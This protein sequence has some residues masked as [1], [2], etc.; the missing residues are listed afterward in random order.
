M[1]DTTA[2][3]GSDA[4]GSFGI[5]SL[6]AVLTAGAGPLPIVQYNT[7][8][9]YA[10]GIILQSQ[11][12]QLPP[13]GSNHDVLSDGKTPRYWLAQALDGWTNVISNPGSRTLPVGTGHSFVYVG[14]KGSTNNLPKD[15]TVVKSPTDLAAVLGRV[16]TNGTDADLEVTRQLIAQWTITALDM[17][18]NAP[19]EATPAVVVPNAELLPKT[20]PPP[21]V[22]AEMSF[23]DYFTRASALLCSNP[24]TREDLKLIGP[25]VRQLGFKLC[26]NSAPFKNGEMVQNCIPNDWNSIAAD[27]IE[28]LRLTMSKENAVNSWVIAPPN[29][30]DFGTDYDLRAVVA[31]IG[32]G[33]NK[34][35]DALY[36]SGQRD[37]TNATL[38][39]NTAYSITFSSGQLPPHKSESGGFWSLTYYYAPEVYLAHV[40]KF[41]V[42][43]ADPLIFADDGSLTVY[44]QP[45]APANATLK[46]NWLP[47][48]PSD[49][50]EF[51]VTL[52]IYVPGEDVLN[53]GWVPPPIIKAT[54]DPEA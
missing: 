7:D 40:E 52:R 9:S 27:H 39:S 31:K 13:H 25:D 34:V 11:P 23:I 5:N 20:T 17:K 47:S 45:E 24:P 30:G 19:G 50:K 18:T 48:S 6:I 26:S 10:A 2:Y 4:G 54:A 3:G 37:A 14:P 16:Y 41:A 42:R 51:S 49:S 33:A 1:M 32:I 36:P 46:P 28:E 44:I 8:T 29:I 21:Q 38:L 53:G 43:S 15:A 35:E 22:V 12:V